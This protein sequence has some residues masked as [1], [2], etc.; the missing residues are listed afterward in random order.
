MPKGE[1]RRGALRRVAPLFAVACAFA[2]SQPGSASAAIVVTNL[3][4]A[5]HGTPG[6]LRGALEKVSAKHE[7]DHGIT[8]RFKDGLKGTIQL[9]GK[10]LSLRDNCATDIRIKGPGAGKVT[11]DAQQFSRV[12][13]I[14]T[15]PEGMPGSVTVAGLTLRNGGAVEQGGGI[16]SVAPD[17]RVR[18]MR[19]RANGTTGLEARGGGI[20]SRSTIGKN[21]IDAHLL[22]AN[23]RIDGNG[24]GGKNAATPG[25]GTG[26]G[27]FS[28]GPG[29]GTSLIVENS[30]IADNGA[31]GGSDWGTQPPFASGT[32]IGGGIYAHGAEEALLIR[33]S[34][35]S[36][37]ISVSG[38][39]P[40]GNVTSVGGDAMGAAVAVTG[41]ARA[42]I[43]T[44]RIADNHYHPG[45][46]PLIAGS[47][48]EK[49]GGGVYAGPS[50]EVEVR[51]T[52]MTANQGS[53]L[54]DQATVSLRNSTV[55]NGTYLPG[56]WM[57]DAGSTIEIVSTILDNGLPSSPTANCSAIGN[58]VSL[59]FN[60]SSDDTC[61]LD[62]ATDSNE[63][64]PLLIDG[65]ELSFASPA[66]D[67]G[68]LP[69]DPGFPMTDA[70]GEPRLVDLPGYANKG[71]G[72][73]A[74]AYELQS[75][76][77]CLGATRVRSTARGC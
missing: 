68:D 43:D 12:L 64:D 3:D 20:F 10:Q 39:I 47:I 29:T 32:G 40:S 69:G 19:I 37:N 48:G 17:L 45:R 77:S 11:I 21:P 54:S 61:D 46:A 51:S 71:D 35:I 26:G 75:A 66:I 13:R 33:D 52:L 28:G 38:D 65:F 4:D 6:S 18:F 34:R 15:S 25:N 27:I 8:I 5:G 60:I 16:F 42:V 36:N 1:S 14:T 41:D 67:A 9:A 62:Q 22:V 31:G 76:P 2:A 73:D 23:S 70:R 44:S 24:A 58:V 7:C 72:T 63:T 74:G 59:G 50:S 30:V 53:V 55:S 57:F 49:F 56:L